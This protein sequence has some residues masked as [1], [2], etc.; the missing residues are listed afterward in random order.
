MHG[1]VRGVPH[2]MRF[3]RSQSV[4]LSPRTAKRLFSAGQGG[5][6]VFGVYVQGPCIFEILIRILFEDDR[7]FFLCISGQ[8]GFSFIPC[9]A[10]L[11]RF[12]PDLTFLASRL[13]CALI[14]SGSMCSQVIWLKLQTHHVAGKRKN[15]RSAIGRGWTLR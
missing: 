6:E 15:S 4:L 5:F 1:V 9:P 3:V 12:L 2:G 10:C 8:G 13:K 14:F 7:G 11:S